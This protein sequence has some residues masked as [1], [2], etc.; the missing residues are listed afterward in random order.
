MPLYFIRCCCI[1]IIHVTNAFAAAAADGGVDDDGKLT[2]HHPIFGTFEEK[3]PF[4]QSKWCGLESIQTAT[5]ISAYYYIANFKENENKVNKV[6][7]K[8]THVQICYK[9]TEKKKKK[10]NRSQRIVHAS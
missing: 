4:R 10:I 9:K 6:N 5:C 8:D 3:T 1:V 2:P 7:D